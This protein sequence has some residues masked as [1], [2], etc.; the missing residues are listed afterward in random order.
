M[1]YARTLY[2]W[3]Q[4]LIFA[5]AG[6]GAAGQEPTTSPEG[7]LTWRNASLSV[8]WQPGER[9]LVLTNRETGDIIRIP[10]GIE[11]IEFDV[12]RAA[13]LSSPPMRPAVTNAGGV[14]TWRF[15]WPDVGVPGT[16]TKLHCDVAI[17][18][19]ASRPWIRKS[20]SI[21]LTGN[22]KPLLLKEV[23]IDTL[24]LEGQEA[25]Q[26]FAG[27]QSYPVL[28]RSFFCGVAF[29]VA[30]A[31]VKDDVAR[32]S[33]KPG[34]RLAS[35]AVR[36]IWPT[37]Y[38][39]SASG[40]SRAAFE[41]YIDSLRPASP[42]LH[43]QYNTWWTAMPPLTE[44]GLLELVE[45]L[46]N[47]FHEPYGGRLDAF[48]L[49]CGWTE[50]KSV[51]KINARDFPNGFTALT[52]AL[53]GI[54][55][56]LSLW[57]SPSSC[58]PQA[59]DNHWAG[60][61]GYETCDYVRGYRRACLAGERYQQAFKEALVD[62][63]RRYGIDHFKLD[64]YAPTCEVKDHGHE[65]GELSAEKTALGFI[66]V[67]RAVRQ[68]NPHVWLEATCFGYRPSPWWL[69]YVNTVIGTYGD[70]APMG[71]VPCPVYRESYTTSRDAF[72]LQ[73][74]KD[75]LVPIRAQEVLGIVHQT[76]MPLQNDAVVTIL[77]GHDFVPLYVHPKY[78]DARRWRFLARLCSWA[79]ANASVL[80]NTTPVLLGEW[81]K[82]DDSRRWDHP[83]PRDPYGYAHFDQGKGLVLLRN[84]WVKPRQAQ[85]TLD[86]SIGVPKS[87]RNVTAT[88]L[89]PRYGT[90]RR[91]ASYGDRLD[92]KLT[93]YETKLL[94]FGS[95][96]DPPDVTQTACDLSVEGRQSRIIED[97]GQV[98]VSL[99][100]SGTTG[101][102]QVWFLYESDTLLP[103]PYAR[104]EVNGSVVPVRIKD[105]ASGW[106]ATGL[107]PPE[108]W[109]WV[110]ADLPARESTVKA[111]L[112]VLNGSRLSAWVVASERVQDDANADRPIP[113]PELRYL[114][115]IEA[116][117]PRPL[118]L[119]DRAR[120]TNWAL[121]EHGSKAT[122][123]SKWEGDY[124]ASLTIDGKSDTRWNS[125]PGDRDGAWLEID[126]G[127]PRA[128]K[129][130]RFHEA[131][132]GR[133]T[134][135]TIQSWQGSEWRDIV[136]TSKPAAKTSVR[137]RFAPLETT[138]VRLLVVSATEVP[139]LYEFE[140]CGKR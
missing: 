50:P 109:V 74:T 63:T 64:G 140:A 9:A 3:C 82:Q 65:P 133:I 19:D 80:K 61:T 86:E 98:Q 45:T 119:D 33:Y 108:H 10:V 137:H 29:P 136:T 107:K 134:R 83:V 110:V 100:A 34:V 2:G 112:E 4:V 68:A 71:R 67:L 102:K 93:P 81:A 115:A 35:S 95:P 84:P 8:R 91:D 25:R 128:I 37:V 62:L 51:W 129:E 58:Y 123:S 92:V 114:N 120:L 131:A 106:Q 16:T 105:S 139:T 90:L 101:D 6:G 13:G 54:D 118:K 76:P 26:P 125:A 40:Q 47:Q 127:A 30:S 22:D 59:Q 36:E 5:L 87:L 27:W 57:V 14:Q 43:I 12:G 121:T 60:A 28:G 79:R 111:D 78:M 116:L 69:A 20:G 103:E 42:G 44:R 49:D 132:G 130:A 72:N 122:A 113:P 94:E 89:Y 41:S 126:F 138:K 15:V 21:K 104:V 99:R 96:A 17:E 124:D 38:G 52:E 48:C 1:D 70:D 135:Y 56:R 23:V 97:E 31:M 66:D 18:L 11:S 117:S 88:C 39:V 73:G 24:R 32:L 53:K 85:L 75:V 77:R 46:R 7:A 55:C